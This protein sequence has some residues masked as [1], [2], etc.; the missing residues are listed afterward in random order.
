[1]LKSLNELLKTVKA[2][3]ETRWGTVTLAL[4]IV[5]LFTVGHV[6]GQL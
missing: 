5:L 6:A 2:L 3:S 1:M 4:V